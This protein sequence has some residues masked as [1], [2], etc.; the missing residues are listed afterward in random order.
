MTKDT[1][2]GA[3]PT[4]PNATQAH[5]VERARFCLKQRSAEV[6]LTEISRAAHHSPSTLIYQFGS[7]AG[8]KDAVFVDIVLE[9]SE[10]VLGILPDPSEGPTAAAK[11]IASELKSWVTEESDAA[12]F[13]M[14]HKPT[15]LEGAASHRPAGPLLGLAA[16]LLPSLKASSDNEG[17]LRV[18]HQTANA[19]ICFAEASGVESALASYLE[20]T[21]ANLDSAVALLD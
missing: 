1:A 7:F 14:R 4:S 20:T 2:V 5:V 8:L 13:V 11:A 3:W 18:V 10:R 9:L 6:S 16:A 17:A 12:E 15:N 21:I 19:V